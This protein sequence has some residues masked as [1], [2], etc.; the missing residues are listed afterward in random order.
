[1]CLVLLDG[2]GDAAVLQGNKTDQL[3]VDEVGL[4]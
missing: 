3:Q 1:M 2:S 4:K